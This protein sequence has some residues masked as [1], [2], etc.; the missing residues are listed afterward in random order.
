MT[1]R[2]YSR[3]EGFSSTIIAAGDMIHIS[4]E[5]RRMDFITTSAE[6][7]K[8]SLKNKWKCIHRGTNLSC[9]TYN[10]SPKKGK[11]KFSIKVCQILQGWRCKRYTRF[12]IVFIDIKGYGVSNR[13][14]WL[15]QMSKSTTDLERKTARMY[16]LPQ[17]QRIKWSEFHNQTIVRRKIKFN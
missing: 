1:Y 2:N 10:F 8:K 14:Y 3:R 9:S 6:A 16:L 11:K 12:A 4:F 13:L 17:L 15:K 7:I 5:N